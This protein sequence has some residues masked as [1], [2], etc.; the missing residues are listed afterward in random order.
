M[1][2][3]TPP[4]FRKSSLKSNTST[5]K[6]RSH[7]SKESQVTAVRMYS[8][9]HAC[10]SPFCCSFLLPFI[11]QLMPAQYKAI[12]VPYFSIPIK[13]RYFLQYYA[14]SLCRYLIII[15]SLHTF[16]FTLYLTLQLPSFTLKC[17]M[18]IS[19]CHFKFLWILHNSYCFRMEVIR[20]TTRVT[21][22]PQHLDLFLS[23]LIS[24]IGTKRS[25]QKD[26]TKTLNLPFHLHLRPPLS[27]NS[28]ELML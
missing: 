14:S 15:S 8:L 28:E 23:S 7:S 22:S 1:S 4:E 20:L 9:V 24:L 13:S 16:S 5:P 18:F 27:I 12:F 19:F 3:G 6:R 2:I 21:V 26:C 25:H 17:F 11:L 10:F